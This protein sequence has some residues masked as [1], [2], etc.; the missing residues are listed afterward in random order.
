ME[1]R[2]VICDDHPLFRGGLVSAMADVPD[3]SVVGQAGSKGEL[4]EVL[5]RGEVD[6]ILL[7]ADLPDGSGL[8]L[9][10]ELAIRASVLVISAH[11]D[12]ELVAQAMRD[13]AV[14][15]VRKDSDPREL[16][17]LVQRA[18][19]GRTALSGDMA[20]R[21]AESLRKPAADEAHPRSLESLTPRQREV[22]RLV[23]EGLTNREIA[24]RSCL[25]EGTVKNHVTRILERAGVTDR[26]KLAVLVASGQ[27]TV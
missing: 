3:F 23:A 11:D 5:D 24:E 1:T 22:A 9:V 2:I 8:D 15:F 18:A 25:S 12:V 16:I 17:R 6:L 13:G 27:L 10:R 4:A 20:L 26:T 21:V 19:E 14:G 7:D